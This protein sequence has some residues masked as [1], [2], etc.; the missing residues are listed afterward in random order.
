M[1][2]KAVKIKWQNVA[3]VALGV[4]GLVGYMAVYIMVTGHEKA[5]ISRS[6][7]VTSLPSA[8]CVLTALQATRGVTATRHY[9]VPSD[10]GWSFREGRIDH[11][12]YDVVIYECG[13]SGGEVYLHPGDR[14]HLPQVTFEST[15]YAPG[16]PGKRYPP[17]RL[18]R[19]RLTLDSIY[20]TLSA[21]CGPLPDAS[22]VNETTY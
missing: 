8:E 22:L 13:D 5:G 2:S 3:I 10:V 20:S 17:A 21:R 7:I 18:D 15:L 6:V 12:A 11:P 16:N 19:I 9:T 1:M 4:L 14:A